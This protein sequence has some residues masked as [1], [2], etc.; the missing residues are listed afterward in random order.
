M[1]AAPILLLALV[2]V[3]ASR[4]D[5]EAQ[6]GLVK[7]VSGKASANDSSKVG[8]ALLLAQ[9]I[10]GAARVLGIWDAPSYNQSESRAT[11]ISVTVDPV[12]LTPTTSSCPDHI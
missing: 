2:L 3:L 1:L 4:A 10:L 12:V 9:T 5:A 7:V 8:A 6:T 11:R